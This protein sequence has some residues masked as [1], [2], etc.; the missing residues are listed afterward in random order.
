[1]FNLEFLSKIE[2]WI[3]LTTIFAAGIAFIEFYRRQ[4]NQSK[5]VLIT[6]KAQLEVSGAWFGG[7]GHTP[8]PTEEENFYY[9]NPLVIIYDVDNNSLKEITLNEGILSFPNEIVGKIFEYNQNKL[10]KH[11]RLHLKKIFD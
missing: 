1:M 5:K 7:F 6:I 4:L 2:F 9:I 11:M 8:N 10:D 3:A